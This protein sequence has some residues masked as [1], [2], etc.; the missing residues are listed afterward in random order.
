M[1]LLRFFGS[2]VGIVV[3]MILSPTGLFLTDALKP[4]V[5]LTAL[6]GHNA[7]AMVDAMAPLF[8]LAETQPNVVLF[9]LVPKLI[10]ALLIGVLFIRSVSIL[11]AFA[12]ESAYRRFAN[13]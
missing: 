7:L 5:N 3:G 11:T 2:L 1:S 12:F 8:R 6:S 10:F 9:V 13:I 4:W